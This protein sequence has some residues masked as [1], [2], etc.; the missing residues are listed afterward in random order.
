MFQNITPTKTLAYFKMC[1][2]SKKKKLG[3]HVDILYSH[4]KFR[5]EMVFFMVCV[6]KTFFW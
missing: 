1:K 4:T 5:K 2:N 6:K 3:V